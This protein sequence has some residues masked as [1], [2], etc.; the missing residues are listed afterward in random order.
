MFRIV[1]LLL[2]AIYS[3]KC[4]FEKK[5]AKKLS[6]TKC[7]DAADKIDYDFEYDQYEY[8]TDE[9]YSWGPPAWPLP[10]PVTP[11]NVWEKTRFKRNAMGGLQQRRTSKGVTQNQK[12]KPKGAVTQTKN[13]KPKGVTQN[14]KLK[15][16][17]AVTQTE[18]PKPKGVKPKVVVTQTEKPK[19]KGV[20]QNQKLK[21]NAAVT[22]TK[23]PKPNAAVTESKKL[24]EA[25]KDKNVTK[26]DSLE[27]IQVL[28]TDLINVTICHNKKGKDCGSFTD[29][30]KE[31]FNNT[32]LVRDINS[33]CVLFVV[34]LVS[35]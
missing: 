9:E 35:N 33:H 23:K 32:L 12:L 19:P 2:L 26:W 1:L 8:D 15:P 3:L 30:A 5:N 24:D 7:R 27:K 4:V 28:L 18:K 6:K 10:G 31:I 11:Y 17:G 20:T 25:E 16:K 14:Q 21:P 22:Q 13:P 34:E 29:I